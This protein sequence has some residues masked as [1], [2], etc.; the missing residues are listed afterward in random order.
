MAVRD[1]GV[2]RFFY[3]SSAFVIN[4]LVDIVENIA[5]FKLKR[6]YDLDTPK[7]V[8]GRNGDNKLIKNTWAWRL[9]FR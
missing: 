7:G 1:L 5:V 9:S 6:T 4:K 2:T 8:H 3:A